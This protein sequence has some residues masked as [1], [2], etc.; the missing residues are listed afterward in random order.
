MRLDLDAARAARA[1]THDP[2]VVVLGGDEYVIHEVALAVDLHMQAN[3]I[4]AAMRSL[5]GDADGD[6]ILQTAS[7]SRADLIDLMRGIRDWSLG[8]RKADE[9]NVPASA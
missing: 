6:L 9:G 1:E 3:D 8:A 4:E 5:F 2:L 7:L